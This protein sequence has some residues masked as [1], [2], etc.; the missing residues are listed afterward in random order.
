MFSYRNLPN[1]GV[2]IGTGANLL[3]EADNNK[4]NG[5]LLAIHK[6][7]TDVVERLLELSGSRTSLN[8]EDKYPSQYYTFSFICLTSDRK[9]HS[10]VMI[11]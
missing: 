8:N 10:N 4:R 6:K 11:M 7:E 5:L 3:S 9:L 2:L 1:V